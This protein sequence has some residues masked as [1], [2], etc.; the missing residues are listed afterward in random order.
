MNLK[1]ENNLGR[2]GLVGRFKPLNNG[3]YALLE[4]ICEKS[5]RV[6]IG[7]GSSNRYN[8]INPFTANET[9]DMIRVALHPQFSNFDIIYIPDLLIDIFNTVSINS[10]I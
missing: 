10:G 1:M 3:G 5:D 2:V 7:V 6:I 8:V 4:A 9:E